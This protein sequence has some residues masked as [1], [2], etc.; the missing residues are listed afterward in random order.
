MQQADI[1]MQR[2]CHWLFRYFTV[3]IGDRDRMFFMETNDHLRIV[4]T[5]VVDD[6][7]M[8][9]AIARPRN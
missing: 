7:V 9:T 5:E 6:A 2:N 1:G 8:K 4:V 3:A